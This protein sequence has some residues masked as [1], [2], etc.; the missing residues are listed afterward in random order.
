[1][2]SHASSDANDG[3]LTPFRANPL[4]WLARARRERGRVFALRTGGAVFSRLA[5]CRAVVAAFG[6]DAVRQ[7][8]T[9]GETFVLPASAAGALALPPRL[10]RLNRSL[11]SMAEP[12][13]GRHK[14]ALGALLGATAVD[15]PAMHRA[16]ER[17]TRQWPPHRPQPLLAR[18]RELSLTLAQCVLLSP[19]A[20]PSLAPLLHEYF[21][22]RRDAASTAAV[23]GAASRAPLLA[24][25]Q[26]LDRMLRR[27]LRNDGVAGGVLGR[28]RCPQAMADLALSEDEAVGHANILF[29]SATEPI[30]V[31]LTWTL[32][33]LSQRPDLW[34]ALRDDVSALDRV[35]LESLR[36][37]PPNGFMVRLT[38]R[39]VRLGGLSLPAHAEVILCPVLSHREDG[40]FDR[41]EVFLPQRWRGPAPTPFE[42]FPFGAGGHACIGRSLGMDLLR[43][44][45]GFMVRRF[46][47]VLDA[48]QAIDWRL[49][50]MFMPRAEITARFEPV[51]AATDGGRWAGPVAGLVNLAG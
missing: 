43:A 8:L 26:R 41:P 16:L 31:A 27:H 30:A 44:A 15:V 4:A 47:T 14:R 10:A 45:L 42:Y 23:G 34:C 48:D 13:H 32:L 25:G 3:D 24:A 36:L 19:Q 21:L 2:K 17:A 11:H 46:D 6:A 51:G 22:L 39:P 5:D 29:V 50:V 1:M 20:D 18:M 28:L 37:L 33:L 35:L 7:V 49:H 9:D 12:E 38:T 40:V